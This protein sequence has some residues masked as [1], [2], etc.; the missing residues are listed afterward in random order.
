MEGGAGTAGEGLV[1][2][3]K[4]HMIDHKTYTKQDSLILLSIGQDD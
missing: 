3:Y 1:V 2:A 4:L